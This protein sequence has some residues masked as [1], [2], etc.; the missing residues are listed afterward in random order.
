MKRNTWIFESEKIIIESPVFT[1]Y[2]R[3]CH[4]SESESNRHRFY[5]M[6]SRD[7]CNVIP[8]TEQGKVV[9]VR[10]HRIGV[11]RHTLEIPGGVVDMNDPNIQA[12]AIREMTE[13]TGFSPLPE[14]RCEHLGWAYA[15]PAILDNKVHSFIVGPVRRDR[16]Q[17]LDSGEM[18]EVI[19]TPIAEIPS[20]I[21][22]GEISHSLILNAFLFLTL[23]DDKQNSI[24]E[25][26]SKFKK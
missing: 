23:S 12:A 2:E 17:K 15:N 20:L 8:V 7:W 26:L 4:S 19:E 11:D 1:I 21:K 25:R 18:V 9:M 24:V 10:Q 14:A 3:T 16:D 5:T 6:K 22:N 13:E